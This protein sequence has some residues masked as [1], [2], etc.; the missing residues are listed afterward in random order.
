MSDQIDPRVTPP[1]V[2]QQLEDIYRRLQATENAFSERIEALGD[3]VARLTKRVIELEGN[4]EDWPGKHHADVWHL[5]AAP[6]VT[7][8]GSDEPCQGVTGNVEH[9]NCPKCG[10]MLSPKQSCAIPNMDSRVRFQREANRPAFDWVDGFGS[11][12]D[13]AEWLEAQ[14][15]ALLAVIKQVKAF[16]AKWSSMLRA[17]CAAEL[18]TVLEGVSPPH[19]D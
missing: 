19:T 15:A 1:T 9:V 17:S 12:T 8:C 6:G 11:T 14:N 2:E 16:E 7:V 18:R 10:A 13:Y 3:E 4:E 5:R